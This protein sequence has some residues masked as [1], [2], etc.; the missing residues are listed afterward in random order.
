MLN[1]RNAQQ[2]DLNRNFPDR[3]HNATSPEQ[4][5]T[6][7][8]R[9]WLNTTQ[10]VLSANLHGG[11]LVVN[12]PFDS[13]LSD[14]EGIE[15]TPD[16]DV[17]LHLSN[18][19]ARKHPQLRNNAQCGNEDKF[20]NGI[21]N[22]NAWYPVRGSMQDYNY[23]FGGCMD[24]TLELSC[25]KHPDAS[26]LYKHWND[27]KIALLTFLTEAHRGIKGTVK[28][29]LTE[30]P[31]AK[32]NIT[33]LGR[34]VVFKSDNQGRFWRILLP[35][36]YVLIIKANG[37]K[38]LQKQFTVID[39][40]ISIIDAYL[41][42]TQRSK[43]TSALSTEYHHSSSRSETARLTMS[44]ASVQSNRIGES[45]AFFFLPFFVLLNFV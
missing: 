24:V 30:Q 6:K 42:P 3:N 35:G 7:A 14:N 43:R 32:A 12:Y 16:H 31:I 18:S 4:P 11:A 1:R 15:P 5:E 10:F 21:T 28:N 23:I 26:N 40:K 25:C 45:M 22:G 27:N 8:I 39:N 19:Y 38:R 13:G 9:E 2:S 33:I 20:E 37:Y 41:A 36:D 29:S 44:N 17:F 34:N